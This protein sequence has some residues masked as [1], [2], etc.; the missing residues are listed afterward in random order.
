MIHPLA[1]CNRCHIVEGEGG[2]I[3]PPLDGIASRHSGEYLYESL[4]DP[5]AV[6]AKGSPAEISPM[7]PAGVLLGK[8]EL[9]DVMAYLMTLK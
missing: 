6:M 4:V 5:Q 1:A 7:P 2:L 8:Q 3:G 9:R